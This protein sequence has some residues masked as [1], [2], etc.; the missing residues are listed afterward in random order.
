MELK[1]HITCGSTTQPMKTR[2]ALSTG[3]VSKFKIV[4]AKEI[5]AMETSGRRVRTKKFGLVWLTML[6]T[7]AVI[8][9]PGRSWGWGRE[10]HQIV[11]AVSEYYLDE[12]TKVMIQSLIGN[13]HLYSI[14]TWADD[15]RRDRR[16]TRAWHYVNIPLGGTYDAARDCAL[17]RSCIVA[18]IGDLIQVMKDKSRSRE[19]RAEALK[20][21]VHF[22]GDIHQPMHT[23]KEAA[24]GNSVHVTFLSSSRCGS[25]ECNLHAVWDSSLI[26]HTGLSRENYVGREEE[27]IRT[28]KL[29][30]QAGGTPE[31]WANESLKLAQAAWVPN[32]ADLDEQY[33]E[34]QIKVVDRQMALAG[35]RLAKLLN[36]TIG[37]MTPRDF[38]QSHQPIQAEQSSSSSDRAGKTLKAGDSSVRVWVNTKSG[39]YHCPD[40]RWYGNT[41]NGEYM[42]ES[43][44]MKSGYHPAGGKAC[45]SPQ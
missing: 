5:V 7:V 26:E 38:A 9:V 14:A 13:N 4:Y 44:A 18:K 41:K 35:L 40:T 39:A 36:E 37:K 24:G 25:Y 34:Q 43:E 11:A 8:F 28:E 2:S 12:T 10:G 22:V 21:V 6:V 29:D 30:G 16:D 23:V 33:Y 32:G 31:Q 3:S 20:F 45:Q 19:E 1:T 15:V 17:P 42:S 27:L